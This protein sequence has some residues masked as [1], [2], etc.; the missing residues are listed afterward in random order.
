MI[1]KLPSILCFFL[2]CFFTYSQI[3]VSGTVTDEAGGA[4]PGI[5]VIIA[6][7]NQGTTTDFDGNYS[8]TASGDQELEFS[9]LGFVTQRIA[10]NNQDNIDVT[11]VESIEVLDEIVVSG[12]STQSRRTLSGAIGSVDV[13][14][15]IKTPS[16]NV[17]DALQGRVA[18]VNVVNSGAPGGAPVVTI[19]GYAT[20]NSNNPLYVIDGVQT[21]DPNT[22]RDIN[23]KDIDKISVLKDGAAAIYGARASNGVIVVTTKGGTYNSENTL[24]VEAVY[25]T[26][27]LTNRIELLNNQQWA[28]MIWQSKIN[29]GIAPSHPQLGSGAS[30]VI[31]TAL[32]IDMP[33][34]PQ[35]EG[36]TAVVKP[37]G[38]RWM[39]ELFKKSN[40]LNANIVARGG[41]ESGRYSIS[42]NYL[43]QEGVKIFSGY[44]RLTTRLNSEVKIGDKLT[45]GEHL[46]VTYDKEQY[47]AGDFRS[48]AGLA[49]IVPVRDDK[50][51]FAG[52]Y[53][54]SYGLGI[55]D[56]P[57]AQANRAAD[58][59]NKNLRVI[60]DIFLKY[61]ITDFLTFKT[62]AGIQMRQLNN[63]N[64]SK[65][66]PEHGEAISTQTL[67]ES[68]FLNS[69][70]VISNTLTYSDSFGDHAID[71]LIG[72]E[73][74]KWNQK[75][76]A[77][78]RTGYLFET[79]EFYLLSN[80][81]GTPVVSSGYDSSYS[82]FSL[83]A[84]ANYA[85]KEKYFFT[86]TVRQDA[87]SR[88]AKANADSVFPSASV[89]W[90]MSDES[91][92]PSGII[93]TMKLRASYG[94]LG[95]QS[96]TVS[97]PDTNISLLSENAAFYV[98]TG[99]GAATTGAALNSKGNPN[100]TWEKTIS[101]NFAIDLGLLDN[102]LTATIDIFSNETQDLI[103]QDNNLISSTA[104]DAAAPYVNIGS[105]ETKGF[106]MSLG[107]QNETSNGLEYGIK[108][109][110]TKADN[111]VTS[112]IAEYYSGGTSRMGALTRTAPG[113]PI[114]S[115]YGRVADGIFQNDGEVAAHASQDGAAPGRLRYKDVDG[116]GVINDLDRTWIGSPHPDLTYGINLNMGYKNFDLSAFFYGVEGMD[117]YHYTRL[118]NDFPLF[119]NGN[120]STA[121][122]DS[123]T[124]SNP[125]AKM[126]ALSE[127]IRNNE[128]TASNSFFVEDAS[129]LRLRSLQIGYT[130][131][132]AINNLIGSSS[133]RLFYSGYNIFTITDWTG[134]DP[135]VGIG[136][137]TDLGVVFAQ[138]PVYKSHSIGV[139]I[140]F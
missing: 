48:A 127:A 30:P 72:T 13:A 51:N 104:I 53:N 64:F 73:A 39:D 118:Y 95:N 70:W 117:L 111:E 56:S 7:T 1:K 12:Y 88:F 114:S 26:N 101:Q 18:G 96:L 79:P 16:T 92:F 19:R 60:G 6:G 17:A 128:A 35:Y 137:T 65:L 43:D 94:I 84:T 99:S 77:V 68:S 74:V 93:S 139:N 10:I 9:S 2:A 120:R 121:V 61:D 140:K 76:S 40:T 105:M 108:A 133:L 135:E 25:G 81:S 107:Y 125:N 32:K 90:L 23:P 42:V 122:L 124:P 59:Y 36:A 5:T 136:G 86:A 38:T 14:D 52:S 45:L 80:G 100:L 67:T 112:L 20:T 54:N 50:G 44:E 28:D 29:D 62:S 129:Y 82:L 41:S 27:D 3:D 132:E 119:F 131:P 69:E 134:M 57:I 138:T 78:L 24:E 116:N 98:F 4:I 34:L 8:I 130:F 58:N 33:N 113:H 55:A 85:F 22:L 115:Y 63:R 106:D 49:P 11:M 46:N 37:G 87:T 126:P 91:F 31:P 83:F 89:G 75:G 97:N 110:I 123:W 21:E 47:G 103:S 71:A 66:N 109:N 102:K 15:A